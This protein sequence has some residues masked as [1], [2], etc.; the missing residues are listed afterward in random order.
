MSTT[1][2]ISDELMERI[3]SHLDED[4]SYEKFLEELI[5]H[6]EVEGRFLREGYSG[7]P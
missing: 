3:E 1:I 2:E 7:E 4:E 6:Y 5:S